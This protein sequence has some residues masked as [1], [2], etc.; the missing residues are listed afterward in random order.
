M[1]YFAVPAGVFMMIVV[2]WYHQNS[3]SD[4]LY[5]TMKNLLHG[6]ASVASFCI[7]MNLLT[8]GL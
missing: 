1:F 6:L 2:G 3:L 7:G 8:L 5:P 4:T